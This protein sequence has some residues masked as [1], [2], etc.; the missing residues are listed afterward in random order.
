[1][2]DQ[3]TTN[4]G[5]DGP[6]VVPMG[7]GTW[8]W[9]DSLFWDFNQGD[10]TTE[11]IGRAFQASID[12]GIT[13][14]DTAEVYGNGQSERILGDLVRKSGRDDLL[15]A[16]KWFPY[17][18]RFFAKQS[19]PS[20]L[21]DSLD[22]LGVEHVQLYQVHWPFHTAAIATVME[23]MQIAVEQGLTRQIGVS[24]YDLYQT[25]RAQ[26]YLQEMGLSLAANQIQ[27]SLVNREIEKNGLL[28]HC[29]ESNIT[30]IAYSPL[31]Q[32]MLTGKYTPDNPPGGAR[33]TRYGKSFLTQITPLIAL[34]EEIG[35]SHGG[36]TPAQVALNWV[37][38]KGA[39]PIPGAKNLGQ[40]EENIGALGWSLAPEEEPALDKAT[41]AI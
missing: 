28:E 12:A 1:M 13:L 20:T 2:S 21:H 41:E 35:R 9:G 36:K 16:T 29:L 3:P 18:W 32:G 14:F 38:A 23:G 33:R 10:Y 40:A 15:V 6:A 19:I 31:A 34:M 27:Y 26:V 11:D 22:R 7:I 37:I 25:R 30:V 17:P 4:L 5:P 39:V 24:N 8:S